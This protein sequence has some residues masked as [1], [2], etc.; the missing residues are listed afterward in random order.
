MTRDEL[1]LSLEASVR[2]ISSRE[3][4][5]N[6]NCGSLK[7]YRQAGWVG[8]IKAV[9]NFDAAF[10]AKLKHYAKIRITGEIKD[11][12]RREQITSRSHHKMLLAAGM[13]VHA[14][15]LSMALNI[16]LQDRQYKQIES[17]L[18]V[19]KLLTLSQLK[20]RYQR[21]MVLLYEEGLSKVE[22]ARILGVDPSRVT[23]MHQDAIK[24]LLSCGL[25][26]AK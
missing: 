4:C 21:L 13:S 14:V 11:W 16:A 8:A 17:R 26:G 9:D 5:L 20:P 15:D 25:P 2:F 10:G 12:I 23:Q 7:D 24:R 6:D 3:R 1:I 22:C 18:D 19:E